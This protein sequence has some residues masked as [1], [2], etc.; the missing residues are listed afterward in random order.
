MAYGFETSGTPCGS[1]DVVGL[2]RTFAAETLRAAPE[3]LAVPPESPVT[4]RSGMALSRSLFRPPAFQPRSVG[5]RA[6]VSTRDGRVLHMQIAVTKQ[7]DG[8]DIKIA[9]GDTREAAVQGSSAVAL[10]IQL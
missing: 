5:A 7:T 3:T 9:G 6:L 1:D 2:V 10:S 8:R 4:F